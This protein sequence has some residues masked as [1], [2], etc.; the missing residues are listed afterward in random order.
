MTVTLCELALGDPEPSAVEPP[1][2]EAT[3]ATRFVFVPAHVYQAE[4]GGWIAKIISVQARRKDKPTAVRFKD[5]ENRIRTHN[6]TFA[7]VQ[8]HFKP[9]TPLT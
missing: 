1:L 6:F 7:F 3:A 8:E 5:A 9:L 2:S 4:C